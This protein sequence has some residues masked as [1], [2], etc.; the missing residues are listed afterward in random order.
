MSFGALLDRNS[1]VSDVLMNFHFHVFDVSTQSPPV[2]SLA[3]GFQ[4]CT[5][6]EITIEMQEIKEGTFEYPHKI[7]KSA[8]VNDFIFSNGAKIFDSDFYDWISGYIRGEPYKRRNLLI[9]QYSQMNSNA[10]LQGIGINASFAF[11]GANK[12]KP[13]G[14]LVNRLPARAWLVYSCI[15][16][17]YKASNDFDALSHSPSIQDLTVSC[18]YWVEFNTGV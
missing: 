2:L 15:P 18:K 1:R 14:D 13:L 6:P 9:V 4:S 12:I 8:T 16:Q 3:Y 10:T 5:A 11:D 17:H 7:M